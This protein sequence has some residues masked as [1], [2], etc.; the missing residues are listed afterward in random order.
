LLLMPLIRPF[1]P[2]SQ[3]CSNGNENQML[4]VAPRRNRWAISASSSLEFHG[5]A[6]N[7]LSLSY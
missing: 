2:I 5:I 6:A 3:D 1:G 7:A 4:Q